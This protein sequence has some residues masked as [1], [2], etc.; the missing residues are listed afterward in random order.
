M[1]YIFYIYQT[2][3]VVVMVLMNKL[4]NKLC[5]C[6]LVS[7]DKDYNQCIRKEINFNDGITSRN[8]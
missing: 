1:H 6:C 8:N 5:C 3:I 7:L 4:L 2:F